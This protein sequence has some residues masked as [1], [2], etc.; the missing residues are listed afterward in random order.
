[1]ELHHIWHVNQTTSTI[2][3]PNGV[4]SQKKFIVEKGIVMADPA[5][6][7][8]IQFVILSADMMD[9]LLILEIVPNMSYAKMANLI[10]ICAENV[11]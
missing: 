4:I 10:A 5:N 9:F 1:M 6:K 11:S 3:K 7:I 2:P 8:Q